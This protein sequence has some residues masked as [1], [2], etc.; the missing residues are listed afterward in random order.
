MGPSEDED[1][2]DDED[3]DSEFEDEFEA[4]ERTWEEIAEDNERHAEQITAIIEQIVEASRKEEEEIEDIMF[5]EREEKMMEQQTGA[6][7]DPNSIKGRFEC[8]ICQMQ[9]DEYSRMTLHSYKHRPS[10]R[11]ECSKC[12]KTFTKK[13]GYVNHLIKHE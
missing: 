5:T 8:E 13:K 2:E 6:E 3:S 12:D 11:I 4:K 1:S 7:V 9:F 10:K